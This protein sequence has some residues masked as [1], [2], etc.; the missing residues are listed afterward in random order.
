M[1]EQQLKRNLSS[2]WTHSTGFVATSG[3]GAR[4]TTTDGRRFLD[5]TSGIGVNSTGHCHPK[6]VK[7]IQDQ[8]AKLVFSQINVLWNDRLLEL[9]AKVAEVAP[10][11]LDRFFFSGSGAEAV[12]AAVKLAKHATGKQNVVVMQG[13]FHGRTHLAMAMTTS[14]TGYRLN[15]GNLPAGIHVAPYPYALALGMTEEEAC[16]FSLEQLDLVLHTQTAPSETACVVVEPILGEGGY[17]VPPAGY[18]AGLRRICDQYGL[19]LVLDEIQSG[20]C[21]SGRWFA[22]QHEGI[23]ADIMTMAKGLGSGFP[24]SGIAYRSELESN[25]IPGSHGGT[26]GGG[27]LACAAAIATIQTMQDEHLDLAAAER[28]KQLLSGLRKLQE[29][30]PLLGEVRGRGLM[31]GVELMRD[32]KPVPEA[33]GPLLQEVQDR[34]M[35]LLSCGIRKNV[36]R[37]IPPLVATAAEIDEGLGKFAD[38]LVAVEGR[39]P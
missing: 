31:V 2:V 10:E 30:H 37:W 1:N 21:R 32:G 18:L 16:R 4:L 8:A 17:V 26:Y 36:V 11:G 3:Q 25:W 22:H 15:Y 13:S 6:V 12:E 19:L 7:A 33:A 20:F 35:L 27:P 28:G 5:F 14:K 29:K 24:I 34:D 23:R 39:L 38:A 9:G